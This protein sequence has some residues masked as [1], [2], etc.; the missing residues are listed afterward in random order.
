LRINTRNAQLDAAYA[1][2][3]PDAMQG[4]HVLI[5]VN[6]T[7]D[8]IPSEILGRI[9]EPFFT[10]KELGKGSGLGLAM[11]FGFVKQSGGNVDVYSEPGLGST[12]RIYLPRAQAGDGPTEAE[13]VRRPMV[14]GDET[15]LL[16]E[17]N[18]KLR[19]VAARQLAELGYH[20]LEAESAEAALHVVSSG[21]R[22]DLL[23]TDVVMPGSIDGIE[24]ARL[25]GRLRPRP[26]ILLASGFPE[27]RAPGQAPCPPEFRLLNKPYSLDELAHAVRDTLI[28]RRDD[29]V[30][31]HRSTS[32]APGKA[33]IPVNP[34][35]VIRETV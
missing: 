1:A 23:F 21:D 8:G 31:D 34:G 7:G 25:V 27:G 11:V 6:D 20:V 10:T 19:K 28:G 30:A 24:L 13:A 14:G 35:P 17:D 18:A 5:E 3:H 22:I 2:L 26:E 15:I 33:N 16:V 4:E 32:Q 29:E 12:F 9:F